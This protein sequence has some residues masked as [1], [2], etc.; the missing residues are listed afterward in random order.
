M[1]DLS[2]RS[3]QEE[4]MDDLNSSGPIMDQTLK[5]LETINTLLG[6]NYVTL[7]GLDTLLQSR[8]EHRT[9]TV[10][11]LGCGGG[12]ILRLIAAWGERRKIS[13]QLI[14]FDANPNIIQFAK[15]H[16]S[17][18]NIQYQS[19][20]IFSE[21][22]KQQKFDVVVS[23][24]FFHHF[25]SSQLS[26]FFKQLKTQVTVGI[27]INDLHRHWFAY[28]SI[29]WLTQLFS[30]SPMVVNDAPLSVARSFH[31]KEWIEILEKADITNYKLRWMWAFRWQIIIRFK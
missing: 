11:D 12:D 31:K 18:P 2:K 30:K 27:V 8:P 16:T 25:T 24:L 28:Y 21:E 23:T 26:E 1:I 22:F 14:G 19:L 7:N 4:V 15:T 3:A 10:A 29:K 13:L 9:F 17:E 5:E 20:N 6:G